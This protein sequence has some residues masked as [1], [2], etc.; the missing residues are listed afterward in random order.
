MPT[1][2]VYQAL[3]HRIK[4]TDFPLECRAMY[5]F[6]KGRHAH[7]VRKGSGFPYFIHVR[8]V[9]YIVMRNGGSIDQINAALA[10]DLLE[11][12]DTSFPEIMAV[13]HSEACAELCTELRNN[14]FKI[15]EVGKEA[16]M[17]EKLLGLSEGA[18]LI[19]LAD[20][21]YNSYDRP[22]DKA[23]NRMY[24][25]ICGMLIKRELNDTCKALANMILLAD[26]CEPPK[27]LP[28]QV[29]D[30]AGRVI[31]Y[32]LEYERPSDGKYMYFL[33]KEGVPET[34]VDNAGEATAFRSEAECKE[35]LAT[36]PW[37]QNAFEVRNVI[38]HNDPSYYFEKADMDNPDT[39]SV[40]NKVPPDNKSCGSTGVFYKPTVYYVLQSTTEIA[41]KYLYYVDN[42]YLGVEN[43]TTFE[44]GKATAFHNI[45]EANQYL[46]EHPRLKDSFK[47]SSIVGLNPP[48][49]YYDRMKKF[50]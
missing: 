5:Y 44:P 36:K 19:K 43:V 32:V 50:S 34:M 16:Y 15:D 12:T 40:E 6:A 23:I 45:I 3:F 7:Q 37:L 10:H 25:N 31:Y 13:S 21:L 28:K 49:Y 41:G 8:G 14:R 20:M 11:D 46:N 24:H 4:S 33:D 22:A 48:E 29:G 47:S 42:S 1:A 30:G 26:T 39:G 9:A 18:I 17:T 27:K 2:A 35:Y 38:G